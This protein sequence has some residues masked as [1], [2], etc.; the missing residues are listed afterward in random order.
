MEVIQRLLR[1]TG[2]RG[3]ADVAIYKSEAM[4]EVFGQFF[5]FDVGGCSELEGDKI[6]TAMRKFY[7]H[8][9]NQSLCRIAYNPEELQGN[10]KFFYAIAPIENAEA[11]IDLID[12]QLSEVPEGETVVTTGMRKAAYG[13]GD[14][15]GW[16]DLK[17]SAF[18]TNEHRLLF[19]L[20]KIFE[21]QDLPGINRFMDYDPDICLPLEDGRKQMSILAHHWGQPVSCNWNG[22]LVTE[23][24]PKFPV[25]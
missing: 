5:S 4:H 20:K 14:I 6:F 11:V 12:D 21:I 19:G 15:I 16:F 18:I 7:A 13:E 2:H 10:T 8:V 22:Q 17:R 9:Q 1:P 24:P 25:L 23:N 3:I